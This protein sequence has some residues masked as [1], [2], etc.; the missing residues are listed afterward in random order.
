VGLD[1]EDKVIDPAVQEIVKSV[2]AKYTAAELIT[3]REEVSIGI[4]NGLDLRIQK[5]FIIIDD[6]SI[7]DFEF[8]QIWFVINN[9]KRAK[10]LKFYF[11]QVCIE[12]FS[13]ISLELMRPNSLA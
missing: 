13:S 7:K 11:F 12:A 2:T 6:F 4:K 9:S 1:Y 5:Y 10:N 3:L 8:S